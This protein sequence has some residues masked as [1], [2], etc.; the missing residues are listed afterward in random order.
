VKRVKEASR[1][2]S[3][4]GILSYKRV[5]GRHI[6][7]CTQGDIYRVVYQAGTQ[8]G[9]YRVSERHGRLP[10]ASFNVIPGVWEAP[11]S[12]FNVIPGL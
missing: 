6:Q 10:R 5:V 3:P 7:Q 8:G 1:D 4:C 9:I 2:T 11:E 12:L